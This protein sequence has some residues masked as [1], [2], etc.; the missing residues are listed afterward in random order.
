MNFLIQ[1]AHS[2]ITTIGRHK[3]LFLVL[4]ILQLIT[5]GLGVGISVFYHIQI[6]DQA[7]QI[8][9]V[10]QNLQEDQSDVEP[11][12]SAYQ[13]YNAMIKTIGWYALWILGLFSIFHFALWSTCFSMREPLGIKKIFKMWLKFMAVTL[14]LFV[15]FL[16]I[17]YLLISRIISNDL[18]WEKLIST[19]QM[20]GFVALFLYVLLLVFFAFLPQAMLRKAF[21]SLTRNI[22]R[23][24]ITLF[25]NGVM[26]LGSFYFLYWSTQV[27][28]LWIMLSAALL[29]VVLLVITRLFWIHCLHHD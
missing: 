16:V 20:V 22:F 6:L 15:P 12:M 25:I 13:T 28:K 7:Q 17:G 9:S 26:L 23:V 21:H 18:G 5:L 11:I 2:T 29:M 10:F 14:A 8:I 1:G 3:I 4:I 19:L 24:M 27:E